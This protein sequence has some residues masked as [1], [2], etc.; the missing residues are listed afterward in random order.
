MSTRLKGA[1][2]ID[3]DGTLVKT[4]GGRPANVVAEIELLPGVPEGVRELKAAGLT[5]VVVTNQGGIGLGYFAESVLKE[6]DE[7]INSLLVGEGSPAIDAFYHCPHRLNEGCGCRKP[8]P[9]LFL[10]AA[11]DLDIDLARSYAI[12]DEARDMDA[13]IRAGIKWPLMVV[14]DR[15]QDTPL[16][17][18]VF[19][20]FRDAAH[21]VAM[22][23]GDA[24]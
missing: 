23:E 18:M 7:R 21:M 8:N 2:F 14:S 6:M 12:G 10:K 22:L 17:R 3:R 11:E 19:A 1:V 13:A 9:G 5:L 20:T 24:R 16:A 4:F 15:Y